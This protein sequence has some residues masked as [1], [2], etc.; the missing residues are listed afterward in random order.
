[1]YLC[2]RFQMEVTKRYA[3]SLVSENLRNFQCNTRDRVMASR[4]L[5]GLFLFLC[6]KVILRTF[7]K[8]SG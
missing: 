1:M 3:S 8:R 6:Y 7:T 2:K 5:R 4:V